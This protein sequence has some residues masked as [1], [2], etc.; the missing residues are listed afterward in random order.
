[1]G[2]LG[3]GQVG[4]GTGDVRTKH[5]CPPLVRVS[6]AAKHLCP[7]LKKS[8]PNLFSAST[9]SVATRNFPIADSTNARPL[10]RSE[11]APHGSELFGGT[12]G[13]LADARPRTRPVCSAVAG[14]TSCWTARS[15]LAA[16]GAGGS[17][18]GRE[19]RLGNGCRSDRARPARGETCAR[20]G[21]PPAAR[22]HAAGRHARHDTLHGWPHWHMLR[23][24]I[25]RRRAGVLG[26]SGSRVVAHLPAAGRR[27]GAGRGRALQWRVPLGD[28]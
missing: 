14:L 21:R 6:G 10:H 26:E 28:R 7:G 27:C 25:G 2:C 5:L 15:P 13:G 3:E 16:A 20:S 19:R 4:T 24:R 11:A 17:R 22:T 23:P 18:R 8:P 9:C 1:M 12:L